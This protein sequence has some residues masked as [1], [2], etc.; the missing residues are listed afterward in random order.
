MKEELI[1]KRLAELG[2]L[3]RLQIFRY[4]VKAGHSGAAV[5]E[6]QAELKIPNSTLSHHISRLVNVGLIKQQRDGR[7]LYCFPQYKV[8]NETIEFLREECCINENKCHKEKPMKK[9]L[10]VC[11]ENSCR[12]QMAEA[13]GK[14]HGQDVFESYSSGSKPSGIVN[15]KAIAAMAELSYDLNSHDSKSLDEIPQVEYEYAIT[16]GCGDECPN[17]KAKHRADWQI[18]DPKHLEPAEFNQVRDIIEQKVL[19]LVKELS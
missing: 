2:N 12:S 19:E 7:V 10:F 14:I 9:V 15:P 5:G 1:A 17:V 6:I 16:M 18:P 4:L 3:T 11:V 8:L 13:F